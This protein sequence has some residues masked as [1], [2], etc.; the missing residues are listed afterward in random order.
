MFCNFIAID[1]GVFKCT[2]CDTI[3]Y[4]QDDIEDAPIFPCKLSIV[5]QDDNLFLESVKILGSQSE[6]QKCSD[7]EILN[8]H[9]V[10][11]MCPEFKDD[12]CSQCGCRITRNKEF[13]NKL[14]WKDEKCPLDKWT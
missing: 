13:A 11:M 2:N 14:L 7:L 6:K 4:T 8:R 10:C 1:S 5:R 3:I 12:S 9:N